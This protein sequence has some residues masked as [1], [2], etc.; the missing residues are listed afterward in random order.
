MSSS[1]SSGPVSSSPSSGPVSA[2]PPPPPPPPPGPLTSLSQALVCGVLGGVSWFITDV[3]NT[4]TVTGRD[5]FLAAHAAA[6]AAPGGRGL[7]TASNHVT[8][9][10]DPGSVMPLVPAAWLATPSRLRW[11]LCA[12]DRCFTNP[13][14]G[15]LLAAGRVLPVERGRGALQP[16]M[17]AVVRR[18]DAG[19]W[20]HM[21]PEGRRGEFGAGLGAMR[22]GVG[23]LIADAQPTPLVVPFY[24]RGLHQLLRKG[25]LLPVAV[26]KHIH[27]DVGEPLD[28]APFLRELRAA[29]T[30]ERAI[31]AALAARVG[32]AIAAV[33]ARQCA[34]LGPEVGEAGAAGGGKG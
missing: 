26:G 9:V 32:A 34:R 16:G 20:V 5:T 27:I 25:E 28:L 2:L 4:C 18:L 11:T 23:R 3:L 8:A 30:P 24:H 33:R 13:V 19:E 29:G 21:F 1:P 14:V 7:I 12:A 6:R 15:S 10:D 31:H 17:D 22:P